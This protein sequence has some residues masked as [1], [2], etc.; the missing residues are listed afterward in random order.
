VE[1][2]L[3]QTK[4]ATRDKFDSVSCMVITWLQVHPA[5]DVTTDDLHPPHLYLLYTPNRSTRQD[6]RRGRSSKRIQR[7]GPLSGLERAN[8]Q[9][10]VNMTADVRSFPYW[11]LIIT[12]IPRNSRHSSRLK[13]LKLPDSKNQTDQVKV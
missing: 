1:V 10:I 9:E 6:E 13:V 4:N 7:Y 11:L 2:V 12:N 5:V 3:S 8:K